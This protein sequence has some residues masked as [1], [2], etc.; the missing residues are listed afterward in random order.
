MVIERGLDTTA[1]PLFVV[2]GAGGNL[3]NM[4][5]LIREI[6][7]TRPVIGFQSRGVLG[8]RPH[9]SIPAMATEYI[10]YMRRHQPRGPY[11][12]MGFS[13]GAQA[14]FEMARQLEA[15]GEVVSDLVLLDCAAPNLD[16]LAS[17]VQME[18]PTMGRALTRRFRHEVELM[19][20]HGPRQFFVRNW[21]ILMEKIMH[22]RLLE[23]C[24]R[25]NP[26]FM[27]RIQT[28]Q[29]W[30]AMSRRYQGGA[31]GGRVLLVVSTED[32]TG[33][34]RTVL[35]LHPFL[36]WDAF[37]PVERITRHEVSTTHLTMVEGQVGRNLA[38]VI[39]AQF[40]AVRSMS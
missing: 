36:G 31:Y 39:E 16:L 33:A 34:A 23:I 9:A 4:V 27:W 26:A 18:S 22:G 25:I 8:H 1:A 24:G 6:G 29:N 10:R 14:A 11:R 3:N 17:T 21:H 32:R 12:L 40:D 30:Y 2:G 7:R 38:R 20:D 15:E 28:T 37:V 13:A 5:Q 19:R 35:D